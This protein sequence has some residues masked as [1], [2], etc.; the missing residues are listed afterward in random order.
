MPQE[1][2][3]DLK[4]LLGHRLAVSTVAHRRHAQL[5]LLIDL[6]SSGTGEFIPTTKYEEARHERRRTRGDEWP[7]ASALSRAYGHWLR[8]HRA[9]CRYWFDGGQGKVPA[10]YAHTKR[11]QA[12][13]PE[14]IVRALRQAQLDV[15][16]RR[17]AVG[18]SPSDEGHTA[19]TNAHGLRF[20]STWPTE[21]EYYEW[22]RIKRRLARLTGNRCRLPERLSI[23]TAFGS[24]EA[25][26][27]VASSCVPN[28]KP[29]EASD[30]ASL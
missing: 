4:R 24:Y 6:L 3:A 22:A 12:Y 17:R 29:G 28:G 15:G 27:E 23:Q 21:W 11:T 25:A 9:A 1:A 10:N 7:T 20:A 13:K 18:R 2:A 5:G 14:E 19:D 30:P 26:V 8:A 16:L